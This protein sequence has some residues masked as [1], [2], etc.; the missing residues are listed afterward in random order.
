MENKALKTTII[1]MALLFAVY[2]FFNNPFT[3]SALPPSST[4]ICIDYSK[5][6]PNTLKHSLVAEM[7]KN[8]RTNQLVSIQTATVNPVA[9]DAQC[10]WFPLD[11]IKKFIYHIE[12]GFETQ[13][14]G[15]KANLGLRMYYSAY[16]DDK[17]W[18]DKGYEEIAYLANNPTTALYGRKHTLVLIPTLEIHGVNSDFNPI[19]PATYTGFNSATNPFSN[20]SYVPMAMSASV[21]GKNH[22]DLQPPYPF[23]GNAF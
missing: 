13:K 17:L 10:I 15:A 6:K 20:P 4:A 1:V 2:A 11:S 23:T 5:D 3:A 21:M 8:Y 22:G 19:D 18:S 7:V 9:N 14:P 16:P 12:K